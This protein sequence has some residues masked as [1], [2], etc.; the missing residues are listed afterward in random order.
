M[1]KILLVLVM[2]VSL[3][4]VGCSNDSKQATSSSAVQSNVDEKEKPEDEEVEDIEEDEES[5]NLEK[6]ERGIPGSAYVDIALGLEQR[7]FPKYTTQKIEEMDCMYI[8]P[9]IYNDPDT[10]AELSYYLTYLGT[11]TGAMGEIITA[12]FIIANLGGVNNDDFIALAKSYLTFCATMPYDTSDV[13]AVIKWVD[14][15]IQNT[16]SAEN[17]ATTTIGDA[18]FEMSGGTFPSG[19]AGSR[20]LTIS[21]NN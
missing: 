18:K 13:D 12:D 7:G 10:G 21:K 19:V 15:N 14:E 2:L 4:I 11:G 5:E 1:K 20:R 8:E 3:S 9:V 17:I 16:S 6:D